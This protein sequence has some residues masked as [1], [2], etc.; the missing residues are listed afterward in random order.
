MVEAILSVRPIV[1]RLRTGF[2]LPPELLVDQ[3]AEGG[4][5]KDAA[6]GDHGGAEGGLP[7][8]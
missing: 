4:P 6:G 7:V 3:R 2:S 1:M 8:D 5:Q